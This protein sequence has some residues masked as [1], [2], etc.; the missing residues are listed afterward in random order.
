M[1]QEIQQ[2]FRPIYASPDR[3]ASRDNRITDNDIASFQIW[4]QP[5][6]DPEADK[7]A[8]AASHITVQIFPVFPAVLAVKHNSAIALRYSCLE[9]HARS[10]K[11]GSFVCNY[12]HSGPKFEPQRR[13]PNKPA[14]RPGIIGDLP[15]RDP[16]NATAAEQAYI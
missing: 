14:Y 11:H 9:V 15:L 1:R 13:L 16:E 10:H 2:S 5:A 4:R 12:L 7:S 6:S 8:H 3:A